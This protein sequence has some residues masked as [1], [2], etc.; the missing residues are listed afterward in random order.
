MS[1]LSALTWVMYNDGHGFIQFRL[2]G[3]PVFSTPVAAHPS[4]NY[5]RAGWTN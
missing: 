1:S 5:C 2:K 4:P 3:T